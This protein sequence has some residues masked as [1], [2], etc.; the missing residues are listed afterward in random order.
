MKCTFINIENKPFKSLFQNETRNVKSIPDT[1][2][3]DPQ[4]S[5]GRHREKKTRIA[6]EETVR[7]MRKKGEIHLDL[8]PPGY[9]EN[10]RVERNIGVE[11]HRQ[12]KRI[13]NTTRWRK[14]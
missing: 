5:S 3:T 9:C 6:G 12:W 2:Y 7:E 14:H 8:A 11:F 10:Q 4:N 1:K 13:K